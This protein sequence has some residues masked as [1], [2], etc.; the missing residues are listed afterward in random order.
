MDGEERMMVST[1]EVN[2]E[3][4]ILVASEE[5]LGEQD[6]LGR[7]SGEEKEDNLGRVGAE[8]AGR[9]KQGTEEWAIVSSG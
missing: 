8:G 4:E 6:V 5:T 3:E 2:N 9:A 7:N 1:D